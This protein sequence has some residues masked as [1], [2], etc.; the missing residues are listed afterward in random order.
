MYSYNRFCNRTHVFMSTWS[1]F[2][3][4]WSI[5]ET[6]SQTDCEGGAHLRIPFWHLLMNFEKPKKS[7]FWI[8]ETKLLEISSFY[9]CVP[10]TIII[11]GTVPE[12]WSENFFLVILGQFLPFTSPPLTTQI[13]KIFKE[14]KKHLLEISSFWTCATKNTIKWCM[15]TQVWSATDISFS[16]FRPF[17]AFLPHYWPQN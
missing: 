11:W 4:N 14:W 3:K 10:K 1:K 17:F 12:I 8:N 5:I 2:I 15:L 13:T 7:E 9:T 16:H 6:Y